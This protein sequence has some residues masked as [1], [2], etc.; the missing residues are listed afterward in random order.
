MNER[1]VLESIVTTVDAT[2]NVNIAPMGPH[3]D[4]SLQRIALKPF[5]T[6]VTYQ[7]LLSNPFATVHVVDDVLLIAHAAIGSVQP[8]P[9]MRRIDDRWS[10]LT[11]ACRWF[12]IEID[13]WDD[14]ELR[15]TGE[16]RV[17][18]SGSQRDFF[19]FNRAKHAVIEL[20]ILAT[21][22]HMLPVEELLSE[23]DRLRVPV[24]KTGGDQEHS[25]FDL[26]AVYIRGNSA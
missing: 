8:K 22:V 1:L 4:R 15:P 17:V 6:S 20:A 25:A 3:V 23:I 19:G 5:K 24:D 10:I 14:D 9:E 16:G 26:L 18:R 11:D 2:G 13:N 7:N 12:A 21:R